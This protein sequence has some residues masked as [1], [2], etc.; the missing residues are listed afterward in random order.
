MNDLDL[1]AE[2]L[3]PTLTTGEA[4]RLRPPE[5]RPVP[6]ADTK[7]EGKTAEDDRRKVS[8]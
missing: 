4:E 5:P 7:G 6:A 8:A 1:I 2:L 3:D